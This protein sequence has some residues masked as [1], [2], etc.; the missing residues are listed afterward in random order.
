MALFNFFKKSENPP[1]PTGPYKDPATNS[2][3]QLLFCD[4]IELYRPKTPPPFNYPFDI[5]F[6][7]ERTVADLQKV[8]DDPTSDPRVKMLAYN[9]QLADGHTPTKREL[10]AVIVEVGL[11]EG[12]DVVA[13]FNNGTARYINYTGHMIIWEAKDEISDSLT[14]ELFSKSADIVNKIGPW[15]KPRKPAPPK[16]H[17]RISFLVSDGLYFGEGGINVLFNDPLGSPALTAATHLMKYLTEKS[18]ETK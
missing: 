17:V 4:N 12:L 1:E 5:L 2:I 13:S 11:D 14:A 16:G 10:L 9:L 15:D 3:Y 8:I 7:K 6:S 18:L